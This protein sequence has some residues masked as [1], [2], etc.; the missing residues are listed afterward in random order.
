MGTLKR[1]CALCRNPFPISTPEM[2]ARYKERAND[3]ARAFTSQFSYTILGY[4]PVPGEPKT[5][6]ELE[7]FKRGAEIG[8]AD[9]HFYVAEAYWYEVWNNI[10]DLLSKR[11][12]LLRDEDISV[13]Y[14]VACDI[15]SRWLKMEGLS[16]CELSLLQQV[17]NLQHSS[18][19][20]AEYL[21]RTVNLRDIEKAIY[22][23][24]IAAMGGNEIARFWLGVYGLLMDNYSRSMK[25]FIIAA[26]C[27]HD[28]SLKTVQNG[29]ILGLLTKDD[30]ACALRAHQ[31]SRDEMD[32]DYNRL[33]SLRVSREERNSRVGD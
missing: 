4:T 9:A 27:G 20:I 8:S 16:S 21:A 33:V 29:Y 10:S 23:Y 5:N 26:K 1:K 17:V 12:E 19:D 28:S 14:L 6:K 15:L 11:L 30:Y 3:D 25:H 24:E 18:H 7:L 31:R 22:H 32:A 13:P 2:K